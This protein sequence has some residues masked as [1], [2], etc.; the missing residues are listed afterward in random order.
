M[1]QIFNR[2]Q[3]MFVAV[4]AALLPVSAAAQS[5]APSPTPRHQIPAAVMPCEPEEAQWWEALREAGHTAAAAKYRRRNAGDASTAEKARLEREAAN[6]VER[7]FALLREGITNQYRVP[8]P[9]SRPVALYMQA[10]RYTEQAR[11]AGIKGG[12]AVRYDALA[13]GG[14]TNFVVLHSLG[15]GLDENAIE[16][17][18]QMLFLPAVQAGKFVM[19]RDVATF[20]FNL[21]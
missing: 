9:D 16:A 12:V 5:A 8:L 7:Y 1:S 3:F 2:I 21:Y 4:L 18:R 6:A 13:D 14:V 17:L 10:A 20:S 11:G 15:G 19:N